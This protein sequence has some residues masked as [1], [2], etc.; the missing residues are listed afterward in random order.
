SGRFAA[1]VSSHGFLH[2]RR[3]A[4]EDRLRAVAAHLEDEGVLYATFG[5]ARDGRF[6]AGT[7]LDAATYAP[8]EGDERGV[9][10]TFF[11]RTALDALLAPHFVTESAEERAV[12]EIAG[13]WAHREGP[14]TGAVHWF[15][16]ARKPREE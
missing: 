2:G 6:G 5:S 7:R 8:L 13:S 12:D 14:L 15:V 4:I 16:V 11:D 10:H 9:A 1:V 3:H